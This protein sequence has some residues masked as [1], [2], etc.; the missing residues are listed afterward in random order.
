MVEAASLERGALGMLDH[1][2]YRALAV[3]GAYPSRIS[4]HVVVGGTSL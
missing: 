3:G 2:L 4:D 1:V